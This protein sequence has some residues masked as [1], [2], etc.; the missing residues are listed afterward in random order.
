MGIYEKLMAI[1]AE[2]KVPKGQR[3][4]F[5]GFNYRS[6]EDINLVAKPVCESHGCGYILSDELIEVGGSRYIK[7]TATLFDTEG[8]GARVSVTAYAREDESRPKMSSSQCTGSASSYAR[9]YAL[10]GL[11]SIDTGEDPDAS[12]TQGEKQ[13]NKTANANWTPYWNVKKLADQAGVDNRDID[14]YIQR[15]GKDPQTWTQDEVERLCAY[16][17]DLINR[18]G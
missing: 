18:R 5:G 17:A 10:C 14:S 7:S 12:S 16:V 6:L 15:S 13:E 2:I 8:D 1:S 3:N 9:K 4:E 11:F